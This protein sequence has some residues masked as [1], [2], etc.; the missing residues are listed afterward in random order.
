[1]SNY[2]DL[3]A[4][5]VRGSG[6]Y[7]FVGTIIPWTSTSLTGFLVC[8]GSEQVSRATYPQLAAILNDKYGTAR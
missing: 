7:F 1:M 4:T 5:A 2:F 6:G 8:D 3:K